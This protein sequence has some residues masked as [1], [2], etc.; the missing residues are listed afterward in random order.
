[1][2][3]KGGRQ[4]LHSSWSQVISNGSR[5]LDEMTSSGHFY[6][7]VPLHQGFSTSALSTFW[8]G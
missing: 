6:K 2:G 5:D 1:M 7:T 8:T 3:G 4:C